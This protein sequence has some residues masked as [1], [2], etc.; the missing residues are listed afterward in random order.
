M[1][2]TEAVERGGGTAWSVEAAG[3]GFQ[4]I[5]NCLPLQRFTP[6]AAPLSTTPINTVCSPTTSLRP[7]TS[8]RHTFFTHYL[9]PRLVADVRG[10][11]IK[12]DH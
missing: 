12:G 3:E 7:L 11:C 5:G 6:A 1:N 10:S 9:Q 8:S 2:I 4:L